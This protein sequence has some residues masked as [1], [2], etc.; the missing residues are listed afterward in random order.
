MPRGKCC[1]LPAKTLSLQ[2]RFFSPA[3][4]V[5]VEIH[6]ALDLFL[7]ASFLLTHS[8][9]SGGIELGDPALLACPLQVLVV[10]CTLSRRFTHWGAP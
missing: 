8:F 6:H 5:G 7:F 9:V 2:H 4:H 1:C 3:E 10:Y